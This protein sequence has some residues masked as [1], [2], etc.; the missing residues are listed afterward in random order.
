M[1]PEQHDILWTFTTIAF[2]VFSL[3]AFINVLGHCR[4]HERVNTRFWGGVFAGLLLVNCWMTKH[5]FGLVQHDQM[6]FIAWQVLGIFILLLV[7][8]IFYLHQI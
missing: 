1:L 3:F 7:W 8:G 6:M 4:E 5:M 2:T